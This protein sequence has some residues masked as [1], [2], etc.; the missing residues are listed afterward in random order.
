M[1]VGN[2]IQ[3]ACRLVGLAKSTWYY[4][5]K[6]HEQNAVISDRLQELAVQR[7]RFGSP[8]LTILIRN[9]FGAVNHKRVERLYKDAG[10]VR[11]RKRRKRKWLGRQLEMPKPEAP[12]HRW[13]MDFVHDRTTDGRNFRVFTVVDDCTREAVICLPERSFS[14]H[15]IIRELEQV[16]EIREEAPL[17]FVMDN[18]SEFTSRAF[19]GW[20]QL[21]DIQLDFIQPGKPTQNAF[22]ESFNGR[23]RDE[24]LNMNWFYNLAEAKRIIAEWKDDYNQNRPHSSLGYLPP[25]EFKRQ[26][27]SHINSPT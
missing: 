17:G 4:K 9:E 6:K 26:F 21:N 8:R 5:P 11:P 14:G 18:G 12:D 27:Y 7:P 3:T 10:L 22:V 23:F 20:A 19:L 25:Y 15:R 24:C 16:I 1:S 2:S 13:S